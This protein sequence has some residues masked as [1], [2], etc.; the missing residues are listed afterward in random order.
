MA[1]DFVNSYSYEQLKDIAAFMLNTNKAKIS[2]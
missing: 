2:F 1:Y